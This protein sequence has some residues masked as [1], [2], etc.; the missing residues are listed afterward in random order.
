MPQS[1]LDFIGRHIWLLVQLELVQQV[2]AGI[3]VSTEL[4]STHAVTRPSPSNPLTET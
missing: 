2:V 3:G 4:A 1:P